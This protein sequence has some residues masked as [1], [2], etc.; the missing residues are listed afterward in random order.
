MIEYVFSCL[1]ALGI[2]EGPAHSELIMRP[3]AGASDGE[4]EP[5]LVETGARPHGGEGAWLPMCDD[6]LGVGYN[7]VSLVSVHLRVSHS[8]PTQ[9]NP[10]L[11]FPSHLMARTHGTPYA[12]VE[13][14]VDVLSRD[15]PS[16]ELPFQ[17]HGLT[18]GLTEAT[19]RT[20]SGSGAGKALAMVASPAS[21]VAS[22]SSSSSSF[23]SSS[24]SRRS[25]CS[26]VRSPSENVISPDNKQLKAQQQVELASGD[27]LSWSS[28]APQPPTPAVFVTEV[29][30]VSYETVSA[31]VF[32]HHDHDHNNYRNDQ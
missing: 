5:V 28:I 7:Q 4:L 13:L 6:A 29:C 21:S 20:R 11:P 18:T 32:F 1:D 30:L 10:T 14:M 9:L 23:S 31:F 8:I 19:I 17:Q 25:S 2:G 3:A 16:S 24:S 12:Q 27:F 26:S 15:A 22:S